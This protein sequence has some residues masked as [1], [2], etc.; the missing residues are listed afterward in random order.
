VIILLMV[1]SVNAQSRVTAEFGGGISLPVGVAR[2]H[3]KT[4]FGFVAAAG[5]RFNEHFSTLLDFT[6]SGMNVDALQNSSRNSQ[7]DAQMYLWSLTLNPNV[8]FIKTENFSSYVTGGYGLYYRWLQLTR[9]AFDVVIV[10][11]PWWSVCPDGFV[12]GGSLLGTHSTYK[13]GFNGGA[14][15]TFGSGKKFFVEV[16][17]HRMFTTREPTEIVPIVGGIRW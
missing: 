7:V 6:F 1:I 9:T 11:D 15:V 12:F 16:R 5:P 10:C 2:D 14:G 3:A 4:G 8:E 13:G 17:Y